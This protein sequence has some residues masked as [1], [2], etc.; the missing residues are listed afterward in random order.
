MELLQLLGACDHGHSAGAQA[1]EE[2]EEEEE[3]NAPEEDTADDRDD[4]ED[5]GRKDRG[6]GDAIVQEMD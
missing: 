1:E 4:R 6:A 3:G 2:E 5:M